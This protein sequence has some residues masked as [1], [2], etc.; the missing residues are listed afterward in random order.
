MSSRRVLGLLAAGAIAAASLLAIP[1]AHAAN[2]AMVDV[3]TK[4][5]Y[6][7]FDDGPDGASTWAV[8]NV[9][10]RYKAHAVFFE[11]GKFVSKQGSILRAINASGD[12]I[13]DHSWSHLH[14]ANLSRPQVMRELTLART[15]IDTALPGYRV[16]CF[17]PPYA[18]TNDTVKEIAGQ[19]G[20]KQLLWN[21]NPVDW[22]SPGAT[23]VDGRIV[24]LREDAYDPVTPHLLWNLNP[25]DQ[26]SPGASALATRVIAHLRP[27]SVVLMHDGGGHGFQAAA[28]LP[29]ILRYIAAQ[30]WT[31]GIEPECR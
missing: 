4:V 3:R 15:A 26:S 10:N 25:L 7:T 30:G 24:P 12:R 18:S 8:L 27:G 23:I 1:R 13:G 11:V 17:R 28:A 5:V 6:L 14:M 21:L 16:S 22:A 9:L 19:L 29:A 2:T 31:T 20:M